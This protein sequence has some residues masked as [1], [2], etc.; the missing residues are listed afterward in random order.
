MPLRA[1]RAE[2]SSVWVGRRLFMRRLVLFPA[3]ASSQAA[4]L[5]GDGSGVLGYASARLSQRVRP[6]VQVFPGRSR[7]GRHFERSPG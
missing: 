3:P 1:V 2:E 4:S 7:G 6:S 5:A